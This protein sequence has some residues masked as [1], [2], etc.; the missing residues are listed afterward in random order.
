MVGVCCTKCGPVGGGQYVGV[1]LR[2]AR[3]PDG[4]R[5]RSRDSVLGVFG[6]GASSRALGRRWIVCGGSEAKRR[7]FWRIALGI[8][9]KSD[10]ES[11]AKVAL[12]SAMLR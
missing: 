9:R 6:V 7:S 1:S 3:R 5:G 2:Y 12:G 11:T 10:S 4:G 8:F